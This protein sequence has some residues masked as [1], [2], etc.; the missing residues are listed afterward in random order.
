[1]AAKFDGKITCPRTGQVFQFDDLK[2]VFIS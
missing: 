1:M 2:K